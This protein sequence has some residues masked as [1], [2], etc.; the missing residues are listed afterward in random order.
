MEKDKEL[1]YK[2]FIKTITNMSNNAKLNI[3]NVSKITFVLGNEEFMKK[4]L[5][6]IIVLGALPA[7]ADF[8]SKRFKSSK[9]KEKVS[10]QIV[11]INTIASASFNDRELDGPTHVREELDLMPYPVKKF[12]GFR[13]SKSYAKEQAQKK[14]KELGGSLGKNIESETSCQSYGSVLRSIRFAFDD[15]APLCDSAREDECLIKSH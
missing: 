8:C 10:E 5:L 11:I 2:W 15:W 12:I 4:M 6:I 3:R 7:Y 9:V 1:N 14:C 13:C